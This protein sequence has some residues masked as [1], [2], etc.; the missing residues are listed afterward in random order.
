MGYFIF[1]ETHIY[2]ALCI[3]LMQLAWTLHCKDLEL[4]LDWLPRLQNRE[5][6]ALTNEDFSGF[7]MD[8]RVEIKPEDLLEER[9]QRAPKEE[10]G[11]SD[12]VTSCQQEVQSDGLDWSMVTRRRR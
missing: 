6:D 11:G 3:I 5:A 12:E 10:K 8:L 4:R 1:R 9:N 2:S 7:N